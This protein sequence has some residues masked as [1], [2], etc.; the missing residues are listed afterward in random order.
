MTKEKPKMITVI[1]VINDTR[2][3]PHFSRAPALMFIDET[4]EVVGRYVN[5]G[6]KGGCADK[7]EMLEL[8]VSQGATRAI[9]RNLGQQMLGKLL[10]KN[11]TVFQLERGVPE[12]MDALID[13][14]SEMIPMTKIEQARPSKKFEAKNSQCDC[15][16]GS[17]PS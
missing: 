1:P 4:G 14:L 7:R 2:I 8:I 11:M 12:R 16:D 9:V 6:A 3:S 15:G 5:P 13:Q 17:C 10:D